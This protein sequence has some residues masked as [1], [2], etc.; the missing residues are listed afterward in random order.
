MTSSDAITYILKKHGVEPGIFRAISVK[1]TSWFAWCLPTWHG[2]NLADINIWRLWFRY[3]SLMKNQPVDSHYIDPLIQSIGGF[4]LF[5]TSCWI[6]NRV[7]GNLWHLNYPRDVIIIFG[8]NTKVTTSTMRCM[9]YR[10]VEAILYNKATKVSSRK[11]GYYFWWSTWLQSVER[12]YHHRNTAQKAISNAFTWKINIA[13]PWS[14]MVAQVKL[15]ISQQ[16]FKAYQFR[17]WRLQYQIKH[18][19]II[20]HWCQISIINIAPL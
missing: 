19:K 12:Y 18:M 4:L 10:A 15:S 3:F 6:N 20:F 8:A 5:S 9:K 16:W 11:K 13:F 7:V 2:M 14:F 1:K 17:F